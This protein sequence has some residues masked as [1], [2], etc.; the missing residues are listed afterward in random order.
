MLV[1]NRNRV[2][3]AAK[4]IRLEFKVLN[5]RINVCDQSQF[6]FQS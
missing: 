5:G 3:N 4:G 6:M 1:Q 2:D